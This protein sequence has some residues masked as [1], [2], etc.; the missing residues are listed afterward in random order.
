MTSAEKALGLQICGLPSLPAVQF[1][2]PKGSTAFR[3]VGKQRHGVAVS[4]TRQ[5]FELEIRSHEED[6]EGRKHGETCLE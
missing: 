2:G 3:Y 5:G 6:H 4:E 1:H